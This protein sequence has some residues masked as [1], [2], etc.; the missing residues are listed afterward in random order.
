[1]RKGMKKG[2]K[3]M[4]RKGKKSAKVMKAVKKGRSIAKGDLCAEIET[5]TGVKKS[6]GMK[7]LKGIEEAMPNLL[8][9]TGKVTL[10]G[11]ARVV[12]RRKKATKAG[13]RMMFGQEVK[14]KAMRARNVVKAFPAKALKDQFR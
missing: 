2:M 13:K 3:G 12:I 7:I 8:K 4:A 9:K 14:V 10:P 5:S 6:D 11:I 1:M